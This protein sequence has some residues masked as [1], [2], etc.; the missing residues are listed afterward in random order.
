MDKTT[1][2]G[3]R[4][5]LDMPIDAKTY[6]PTPY[7]R[8]IRADSGLGR[9][10][11]LPAPTEVPSFYQ[12]DAYYTQ[13]QSHFVAGDP[14]TFADKVRGHLAWR[15]DRGKQMD[16]KAI[17]SR[18]PSRSAPTRV[19]DIGCGD[20]ALLRQFS[21]LRCEVTGIDPDEEALAQGRKHILPHALYQGSAEAAADILANRTFDIIIMSHA[22][23]HCIDPAQAVRSARTLLA[24]EGVF[25]VEVPNC[26]ADHFQ[27][28]NIIS[29][30]FDAPRHL[31]FFTPPSLRALIEEAGFRVTE[32]YYHGFTR[33]FG[34][35][36]RATENRIREKLLA[37]GLSSSAVPPAHSRWESA[38]LLAR[39]MFAPP[40][41]KY[42]CV[43]FFASTPI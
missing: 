7:G 37:S 24:A 13:G 40:E 17:L 36:W 31:W 16:P 15:A 23:E 19:L 18:V 26:A 30:M 38:K 3:F 4:P 12:L 41:R 20:G 25:M 39:T 1:V 5:W 14:V 28:F 33:H 2:E 43:G 22:L 6:R 29:E 21:G 8:V 27:T 11:L 32:T 9:A 34:N 35:A 42:D 10:E